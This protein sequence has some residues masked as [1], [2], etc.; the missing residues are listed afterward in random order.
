[1]QQK[2]WVIESF[3]STDKVFETVEELSYAYGEMFKD[4][5]IIDVRTCF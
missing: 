4:Y 5:L 3:P 2:L 1:M